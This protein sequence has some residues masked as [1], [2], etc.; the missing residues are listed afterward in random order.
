MFLKF[1]MPPNEATIL[2]VFESQLM[3]VILGI[4]LFVF[5]VLRLNKFLSKMSLNK[6]TNKVN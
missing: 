4:T 3:F 1:S 5:L 2:P 6:T